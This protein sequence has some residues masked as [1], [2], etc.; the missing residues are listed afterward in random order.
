MT[1]TI[2]GAPHHGSAQTPPP[3][4]QPRSDPQDASPCR[5]PPPRQWRPHPHRSPTAPHGSPAADSDHWAPS[6][7]GSA[8]HDLP[9]NPASKRESHRHP[10][11]RPTAASAPTPRSLPTT[12]HHPPPPKTPCSGHPAHQHPRPRPPGPL[13]YTSPAHHRLARG[14]TRL[15]AGPDKPNAAQ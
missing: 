1:P 10:A 7:P 5:V 2:G 8:R 15:A 9:P 3:T 6:I 4:P 14:H 12:P 11:R 13:G